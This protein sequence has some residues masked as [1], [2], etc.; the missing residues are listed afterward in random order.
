MGHRQRTQHP[1]SRIGAVTRQPISQRIPKIRKHSIPLGP[2]ISITLPQILPS[3]TG[4]LIETT[5]L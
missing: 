3:D 4:K 5:L 1:L 2:Q